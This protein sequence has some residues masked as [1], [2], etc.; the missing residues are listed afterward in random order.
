MS[1]TIGL[2][3][4]CGGASLWMCG[5]RMIFLGSLSSAASAISSTY[6]PLICRKLRATRDVNLHRTSF[7]KEEHDTR[8]RTLMTTNI[9]DVTQAANLSEK[10]HYLADSARSH[11]AGTTM[12]TSSILLLREFASRVSY[13]D[14]WI[15]V[16]SNTITSFKHSTHGHAC[17]GGCCKL[18]G[19]PSLRIFTRRHHPY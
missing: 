3:R 8:R 12:D 17:I 18:S 2:A 11:V 15:D 5:C 19:I 4:S 16:F 1:A 14:C 9:W 7:S 10:T 13:Q 6:R